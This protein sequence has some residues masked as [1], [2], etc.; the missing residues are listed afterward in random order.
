MHHVA[1]C[2]ALAKPFIDECNKQPQCCLA[3]QM[4]LSNTAGGE[5]IGQDNE[6]EVA[7]SP[8]RP[9]ICLDGR[10]E[11]A[12]SRQFEKAGTKKRD[13][14]RVLIASPTA[15][16]G[17]APGKHDLVA[18][19]CSTQDCTEALKKVEKQQKNALRI[20]RRGQSKHI[21]NLCNMIRKPLSKVERSKLVALITIE[22]HA[23]DVQDPRLTVFII[24]MGSI[25]ILSLSVQAMLYLSVT[26]NGKRSISDR[27]SGSSTKCL[28]WPCG[29][30]FAQAGSL[31][32]VA[33]LGAP[34]SLTLGLACHSFRGRPHPLH[35]FGVEARSQQ[36]ERP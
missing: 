30:T 8:A 12:P 23:R 24:Q 26:S 31:S 29:G 11:V 15:H 3:D 13:K 27:V 2:A 18:L 9:M 10:T 17:A 22:V 4:R 1:D 20:V 16:L 6:V 35:V 14:R 5:K 25:A 21:G 28:A 36:F 7:P 32:R 33:T 19:P 34:C